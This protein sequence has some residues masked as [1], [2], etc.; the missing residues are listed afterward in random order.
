MPSF[1]PQ[2]HS[3]VGLRIAIIKTQ[4]TTNIRDV[5]ESIPLGNAGIRKTNSVKHFGE[6]L[7][8]TSGGPGKE[9]EVQK[10]GDNLVPLNPSSLI[11][12]LDTAI[13]QSDNRYCMSQK[14]E[15]FQK[16]TTKKTREPKDAEKNYGPSQRGGKYRNTHNKKLYE[17]LAS[18]TTAITKVRLYFYSQEEQLETHLKSL[19]YI[20]RGKVTKPKYMSCSDGT[21]RLLLQK[22]HRTTKH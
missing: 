3:T 21:I 22:G 17:T 14:S 16:G 5:S 13:L 7:T 12:N 1:L 11:S 19:Q 10:T 18:I 15:H 9:Q 2:P 8:G 6:W 20:S 4:F